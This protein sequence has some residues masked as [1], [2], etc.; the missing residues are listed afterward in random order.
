MNSCSRSRELWDLQDPR[1]PPSAEPTA[2]HP[3]PSSVDAGSVF[4]AF[5]YQLGDFLFFVS[6]LTAP[7]A[8]L[9]MLCTYVCCVYWFYCLVCAQCHGGDSSGSNSEGVGWLTLTT[10]QCHSLHLTASSSSFPASTCRGVGGGLINQSHAVTFLAG[11]FCG[12]T[13]ASC[14]TCLACPSHLDD[15]P[16]GQ[17]PP[18]VS[19]HSAGDHESLSRSPYC[20]RVVAGCVCGE[21]IDAASFVR[22]GRADHPCPIPNVCCCI[23]SFSRA[24]AALRCDT[25]TAWR[26]LLVPQTRL[27]V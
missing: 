22:P 24:A 8:Q 4:L 10:D 27:H 21:L 6:S 14:E 5:A 18:W 16:A 3:I 7:T 17:A 26:A 15:P 1:R 20:Y 13:R 9:I 2:P 25:E 12:Q 23:P 11:T 19:P